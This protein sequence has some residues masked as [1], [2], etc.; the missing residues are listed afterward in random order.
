[1]HFDKLVVLD[2]VVFY[3]EHR[4]RLEALAKTIVEHRTCQSEEEVSER[5][6]GADGIISCWVDIPHRIIDEN[7]QLKAVAF[8][9]H[10]FEHRIDAAYAQD[11][12]VFVPA[13]PDYGTDSVA[14]LV[15]IGLLALL[16]Y[17]GDGDES[18]DE[19]IVFAIADRVRQFGRNVKD[20]L[21]GRWVHEYVKNGELKIDR[22]DGIPAETLKGL[23]VGI[24]E[25]GLITDSLV[26]I[27]ANGYRMNLTY[28]LGDAPHGPT[29][30]YR[31]VEEVLE[32]SHILLYDGRTLPPDVEQRIA[33]GISATC[34]DVARLD[35]R[36]ASARNR[37][38]GILGLG[39]IGSR[40]AQIA[41]EGFGMD[42]MYH[43]RTRKPDL[44]EK[45][46]LRY[47][48]FNALLTEA[49]VISVHLPHHGAEDFL[50]RD[51]LAT[52]PNGR[53]LVNC[54]VGSVIADEDFLF[55]RC[56]RGE[57]RA[58]LD[59]YRRLPPKPR[60]RA[61]PD[62]VIGTYRLGWRTKATVGLKTH[63][64]LTKLEQYGGFNGHGPTS[65]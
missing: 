3:P 10:D 47:C 45:L 33:N 32:E 53:I 19:E 25:P 62:R 29:I 11:R 56:E 52:I 16:K 50:T 27:L 63:K 14:E 31:P 37:R 30:A 26:Q 18:L 17:E 59:V 49:D 1:M 7:P 55:D 40:V 6:R 48:S 8:W 28:S 4:V 5:C 35:V 9:T 57:L 24:L 43:S 58:Y 65:A 12:G 13:I 42:V 2:S 34:V 36:R 23:T 39:R 60:L 41:V 38:L 15:F 21:N 20:A 54:S 44:E 46:G 22:A 64:L 61:A 51:D